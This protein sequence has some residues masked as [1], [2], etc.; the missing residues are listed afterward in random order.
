[1]LVYRMAT[2]LQP[3][4]AN[5]E[6]VRDTYTGCD[7]PLSDRYEKGRTL[8]NPPD[9]LDSLRATASPLKPPIQSRRSKSIPSPLKPHTKSKSKSPARKHTTTAENTLDITPET[10]MD[11]TPENT[12]DTSMPDLVGL[13]LKSPAPA[14]MKPAE[15]ET[16]RKRRVSETTGDFPVFN[17]AQEL[18]ALLDE[19]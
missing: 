15:P 12:L 13:S 18:N 14:P 6:M 7:G 5:F 16:S 9:D 1:M 17:S 8:D 2:L 11:T 19:V 10:T 3:T 4:T